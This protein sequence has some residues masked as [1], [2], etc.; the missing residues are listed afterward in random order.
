[1]Y[2]QQKNLVLLGNEKSCSGLKKK[3]T[4]KEMSSI[5]QKKTHHQREIEKVEMQNELNLYNEQMQR[6]KG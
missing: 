4:N 5:E 6:K 2:V 1:M 3:S